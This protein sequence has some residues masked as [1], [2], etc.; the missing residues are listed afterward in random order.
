[1]FNEENACDRQKYQLLAAALRS[2]KKTDGGQARIVEMLSTEKSCQDW[3]AARALRKL[4]PLL[5]WL[6]LKSREASFLEFL[7]HLPV[8]LSELLG[9]E[10]ED[11]CS[12]VQQLKIYDLCSH[13]AIKTPGAYWD[14]HP[15]SSSVWHFNHYRDSLVDSSGYN[16]SFSN[17]WWH[18][19][20]CVARILVSLKT[21]KGCVNVLFPSQVC[22]P[23]GVLLQT[24]TADCD[25]S[26][27]LAG[28]WFCRLNTAYFGIR[29]TL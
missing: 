26:P 20:P 15:E 8:N 18:W 2:P 14:N 27:A 12:P 13:E 9:L 5:Y 3:P 7:L 24:A 22:D 4:W 17:L 28:V 16:L 19:W 11:L 29:R 21:Q 6:C 10:A 1:M 23:S 25:S